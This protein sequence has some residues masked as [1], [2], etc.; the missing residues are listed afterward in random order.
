MIPCH[1]LKYLEIAIDSIAA[2]SLARDNFETI[3]IGDRINLEDADKVLNSRLRHYEIY[4]SNNPG[5]VSALN[6]GL[7]KCNAGLIVRMDEDDLMEPERLR[8]QLKYM[9]RHPNCVA[10]GGQLKLIDELGNLCGV[11][12]YKRNVTTE[13]ILNRSPIAHP[14]AIFR[15]DVALKVGGYRENLP[16]DWDLWARLYNQGDLKNLDEYILRYRIHPN[17]LSRDSLYK[18]ETSR[19]LVGTSYFA[20]TSGIDDSP[21][22]KAASENWLNETMSYLRKTNQKF[23]EF[24]KSMK[25]DLDIQNRLN[26]Q[27]TLVKYIKIFKISIRHPNSFFKILGVILLNKINYLKIR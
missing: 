3:L 18:Y 9:D 19:R 6:L 20:R 15:R 16:E 26:L 4:N 7:D 14:A 22:S 5:I 1:S 23:S 24:E 2:Q 8:L 12:R 21:R 10:L 27:T 13:E 25:I 11:S 17:Q